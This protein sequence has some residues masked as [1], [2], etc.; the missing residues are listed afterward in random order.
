M[1][2]QK[3]KLEVQKMKSRR[4]YEEKRVSFLDFLTIDLFDAIAFARC[5]K[6]M[7]ILE[8][9]KYMDDFSHYIFFFQ[10]RIQR[11]KK[12]RNYVEMVQDFLKEYAKVNLTITVLNEI[13]KFLSVGDVRNFGRALSGKR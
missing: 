10:Q 1:F 8:S 2:F 4:I 5:E 6:L 7:E 11:V 3:S 12:L 9:E 13:F